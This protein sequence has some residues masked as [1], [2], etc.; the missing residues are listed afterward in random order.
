M[1]KPKRYI[2]DLSETPEPLAPG[3]KGE[4]GVVINTFNASEH[5]PRVL[6][7]LKGF[8]DLVVVD[9]FSD[10]D[11]VEIARR[12]GARVFSFMRCNFCE[13]ARQAAIN[14][15]ACEWVL[16][17]DADE[18]V[19]P[20]LARFLRKLIAEPNPPMALRIPRRNFFMDRE[21]KCLYPDYVTRF[22]RRDNIRW[23]KEIHSSPIVEGEVRSIPERHRELALVH[24]E[25][26]TIQ[27]R[28]E[29]IDRYT[30]QEV[31]RRGYHDYTPLQKA[32]KPAMRFIRSYLLKGGFRDGKA[33]LQWARLEALYKSRTM[34]KQG[35]KKND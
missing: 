24:L 8:D 34:E 9:M 2:A 12:A 33:G 18:E 1:N 3:R 7:S 21:M 17:V 16:V 4:I 35:M 20:Q 25:R 19:T 28:M 6:E 30:D 31:A 26:N 10:D 22:A 13:P 23:P 27:S 32:L 14:A 11:T 15:S 5:L 29:K